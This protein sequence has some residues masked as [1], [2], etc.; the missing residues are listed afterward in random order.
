MK[1]VPVSMDRAQSRAMIEG[2]KK[3]W[4]PAIDKAALSFD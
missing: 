1:S 2:F 4:V 3:L